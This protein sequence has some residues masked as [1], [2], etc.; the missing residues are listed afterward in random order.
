MKIVLVVASGIHTGKEV[1]VPGNQLVIGRDEGCHLRPASPAISKKHCAVYAKD[2]QVYVRDMGSTNGTFVNDEQITGEQPVTGGEKL[3]VGPLDFVIKIVGA[4]SDSTPLPNALKSV[5]SPLTPTATS[6]SK[7][8]PGAQKP[9]PAPTGKSSVAVSPAK[10]M[11]RP[12]ASS[13]AEDDNDDIAALLLNMDAEDGPAE[14]P[15]GSTVMEMPAV[16]GVT[17]AKPD[18]KK[19]KIISQADSSAFARDLLSKMTRRPR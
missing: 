1:A 12:S 7:P 18:E 8:T 17:P 2:G 11:S 15:E 10:P 13:S 4:K 14:V 6:A 16:M 19:D 5:N 9:V 3:R